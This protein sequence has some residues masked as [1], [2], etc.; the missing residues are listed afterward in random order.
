MSEINPNYPVMEIA[1]LLVDYAPLSSG[2]ERGLVG[3][4]AAIRKPAN[5]I[6][7]KEAKI[8]L[9]M[10]IEGLEESDMYKLVGNIEGYD[11]RRYCIPL[12]K[13]KQIRPDFNEDMALNTDIIYQPFLMIDEDDYCFILDDTPLQISGLIYDKVI[14]DYL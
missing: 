9:W 10:R 5:G 7:L 1:I 2:H 8:L 6:G 13:I 4:V 3:D 12:E 11:K 14:G